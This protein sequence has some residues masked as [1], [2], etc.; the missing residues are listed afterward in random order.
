LQT[1]QHGFFYM[2]ARP[3]SDTATR[4]LIT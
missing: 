4:R 1:V 2:M 3:T